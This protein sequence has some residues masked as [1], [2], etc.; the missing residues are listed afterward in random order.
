MTDRMA[1]TGLPL[2]LHAYRLLTL[3]AAPLAPMLLTRRLQRGKEDGGR[4][5]ERYGRCRLARPPGPLVWMHGAS[6]GEIN[7]VIP[8]VERLRARGAA[9]LVTSGTVASAQL[10]KTRLPQG[11]VHQFVPLDSPRFV[12]RFLDHWRPDIALFAES[13]LW[14]NLI[15]TSAARDIP[16]ILINGRL[17]ERSFDRW[18]SWPRTIAALLNRFDLC[19]AQSD[20]DAKRYASL[21]APSVGMTGNLKLDV[22]APEADARTHDTLTGAIGGR[23][24]V[25]AASTHDGEEVAMFDVHQRLR[26]GFPDLLT[27]VVPRHAN[28]GGII[29]DS[30][31]AA[32]LQTALRSR[33][34]LP[35]NDTDIYIAD[36]FGELGS[37]YRLSHVVFMGGSLVT[38]GGQN[39]IEPVK[40]GAAILHG[41][42]VWNFAEI[43]AALDG[44][45]GAEQVDDAH[46]LAA[47][48][49]GWLSDGRARERASAAALRAIGPLCGALDRTLTALEP[50]LARLPVAGLGHA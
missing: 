42:H 6:V 22:P 23:V 40:L 44:A 12:A 43:Y 14:P 20:A 34:E 10:A 45:G 5:D 25:V 1:A 32:S 16:L 39:P 24:V 4:I 9:V 26:R 8:L 19:L 41:P 18:R 28:R 50:R 49:D 38:H 11:A 7:A 48:I 3:A 33:G 13:D 27:I 15:L 37:I 35:G 36:T 17:S 31:R 30:A 29:A 2:T 21:G 46:S 47:R